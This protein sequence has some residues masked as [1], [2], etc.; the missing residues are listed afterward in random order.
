[1]TEEDYI[2]AHIDAEPEALRRLYRHTHM[3]RLYPRMCTDHVQG[4][5]LVMLT[6]MINP[7]RVLELGTF[8]GYSTLCF[9]EA[10]AEG[11]HIDTVELD[12]EYA[13]DLR[14]LFEAEAPGKITLHTGDAEVVVP[15]LLRA[16][17]YDMVFVDANKRR[18]P[19]YYAMLIDAL[20]EGAYIL[21]DNTLWTDKVLDPEARDPQTEGIRVF[22]DTVAADPRVEKVIL[23]VRDGLTVIRKKIVNFAS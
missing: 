10:L 8:S 5:I 21:A 9:A 12:T 18:Y 1:M 14:E 11:G 22:N 17:D 6:R 20:R 15:G 3:H 13:D 7:H 23:P 2:A 4:R 19:Q 16:A